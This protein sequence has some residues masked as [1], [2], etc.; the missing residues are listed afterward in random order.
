MLWAVLLDSFSFLNRII[1]VEDRPYWRPW[2][3]RASVQQSRPWGG[4][5]EAGE[6]ADENNCGAN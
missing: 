4:Y 2:C 1:T 3:A 6:R 5:P